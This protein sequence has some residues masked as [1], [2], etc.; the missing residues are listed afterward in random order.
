MTER[1]WEASA[2]ARLERN[3]AD[4][5][6]RMR[7]TAD[8]IER[9]A[10]RNI[11]SATAPERDLEF[12][13]YP[14]A[15]GQVVHTIQTMVFNLK[16]DNAIE[17]AADA[18]AAW[19]E[20]RAAEKVAALPEAELGDIMTARV[21]G[22]NN[23]LAAMARA[24]QGWAEGSHENQVSMGHRDVKLVPDQEFVL[25]DILNMINDAARE[26]GVAPN[27]GTVK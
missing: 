26:V 17:S 4:T 12:Q 25:A 9:E 22:A 19:T 8:Q 27:Y 14:R 7:D 13:T 5:V 20:K 1:D 21:N 18:E 10:K 6:S 15:A 11:L 3:I 24:V 23:A 2:R 16:L